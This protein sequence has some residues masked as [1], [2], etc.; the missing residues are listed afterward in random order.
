MPTEDVELMTPDEERRLMARLK[1]LQAG[2]SPRQKRAYRVARREFVERWVPFVRW[3]LEHKL[4]RLV[5]RSTFEDCVQDGVTG[6]IKAV[7]HYDPS[8]GAKFNT[9]AYMWVYQAVGREIVNT[10]STVRL[11]AHAA[12]LLAKARRVEA[13]LAG[14]DD[15]ADVMELNETQRT[16]LV[17]ARQCRRL[18]LEGDHGPDSLG[19]RWSLD[20][21]VAAE[22]DDAGERI[23]AAARDA[24]VEAAMKAV[25]TDRERGV[26]ASRYG[27]G[28]ADRLSLEK[29]SGTLGVTKER[30]R[31]IQEIALRKL[32]RRLEHLEPEAVAA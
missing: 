14:T 3:L 27:L 6:L 29:I 20:D 12:Q 22:P 32:R 30:V 19:L 24:E 4:G 28:G 8:Y 26:L 7:D 21:V 10:G 11:P 23:D 2:T 13:K 25:L 16:V 5:E 1:R 18:W 9:Y 31:Q 17:A 15:A